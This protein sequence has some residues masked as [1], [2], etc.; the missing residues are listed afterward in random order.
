[1]RRFSIRTLM[2]VVLFCAV[3]V[4]ALRNASHLWAAL[5]LLVALGCVGVAVLSAAILRGKERYWWAGFALFTG[6]YLVGLA[7]APWSSESFGARMG[8]TYLLGEL[9]SHVSPEIPG[10]NTIEQQQMFRVAR[11]VNID[12]FRRVGHSLFS[13]LCGLMGRTV[14]LWFYARRER[15][16]AA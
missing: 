9:Y 2:A 16:Q 6:G 4:A 15:Q 5:M 3:G 8:A 7:F 10:G 1:M 11:D 14:A 13:L 12:Q